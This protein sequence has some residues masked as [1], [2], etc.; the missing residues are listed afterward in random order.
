[1]YHQGTQTGQMWGASFRYVADS[2]WGTPRIDPG[3]FSWRRREY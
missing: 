3:F 1:V 2:M